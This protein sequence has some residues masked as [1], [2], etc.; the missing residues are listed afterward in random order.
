MKKSIIVN[1]ETQTE[2]GGVIALCHPN[3][4]VIALEI[5]SIAQTFV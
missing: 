2:D 4:K 5:S 1:I 3:E